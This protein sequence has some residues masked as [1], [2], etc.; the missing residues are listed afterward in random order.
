[1]LHKRKVFQG[2]SLS[3]KGIYIDNKTKELV[4]IKIDRNSKSLFREYM[5]QQ[6]FYEES[7][8]LKTLDIVVPKPLKIIKTDN[9]AAL[10][11]EYFYGKSLFKA[12]IQ[13]RLNA[14]M[15]ILKFLKE[16]NTKAN[17]GK[18]YGL[19]QKSAASQL[20]TLPYFLLK[21][22]IL[23]PNY[24]SLFLRSV[25]LITHKATQMARLTSSWI[26]HGDI[27]VD[28]ALICR[29]QVVLLDFAFAYKSHRYFDISR[30][31]NSTWYQKE[32]HGQFWNNI[33]NEFHFTA[34]E[35]DILKLFVVFNLMQRLSQRYK[36]ANQENFYLKRLEKLL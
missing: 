24:V 30:T 7:R 10:V 23:Y 12:D 6:Y 4:F 36:N 8:K 22:L 18:K 29:N 27:N 15:K 13:T 5:H 26:S 16:I 14:Y 35:Q 25:G 32:F 19:K 11:M 3:K 21:N 20:V 17:I 1:M 31:L 33:V 34:Q 9:Y 28:N 2:Q